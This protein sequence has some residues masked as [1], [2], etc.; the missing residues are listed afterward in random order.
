MPS[1]TRRKLLGGLAVGGTATFAG[2]RLLPAELVP[3]P[4]LEQRTK[5]RPVPEVDT[6][7]PV[8]LEALVESREHLRE[9]IDRAESAWKQVDDSDVDSEREDFDTGLENGVEIARDKLAETEDADPTTDAIRELRS[10]VN[11]AAWSLAAAKVVSEDYDAERLGERSKSLYRD[12][13]EFVDSLSYEAANPRRG[14]AYFYRA[15][16]ALYFSRIDAYGKVYLSGEPLDES[17]YSHREVVKTIRGEIEGRRW[18]DDA[19]AVYESHRSNL[20]E[21]GST[22]DLETHL[23]RTWRDF[24][25]RIDGLLVDREEAID[26]YFSDDE[27][28]RNQAVNELVGNGYSAGDDARPPSGDL[29]SGLLALAAVEHAKALQHAL[30]FR[31]AMERLDSAFADGEV[32][33]S[34]AARTKREA[35]ERL[36]SLLADIDDP[37][38]RELAARPREEITI[39]DW[40]L[41]VNQ[42]F[43]SEF[44][45]AEAY[46]MYALAA[47]NLA[48]TA[49]VRDSLLP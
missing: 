38:T 5:R 13:N 31:S 11:R 17:E 8:A 2:Y 24:A 44:P 45:Y 7:L 34:L 12:V 22:T 15:E 47:E 35:I 39:G 4:I 21:S 20:G 49:E 19:K 46:A 27:G 6:S 10:G 23:D 41:G 37:I 29:R 1:I 16:R 32:G 18:L 14:L 43:D 33:M 30:G 40:S 28:P 42:K 25:E 3:A 9:V 36:R 48:H 26:R